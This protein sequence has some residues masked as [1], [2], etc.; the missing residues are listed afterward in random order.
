MTAF[1]H[2]KDAYRE[3]AMLEFLGRW[4]AVSLKALAAKAGRSR[5]R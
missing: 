4:F 5:S 2:G 3:V 1:P